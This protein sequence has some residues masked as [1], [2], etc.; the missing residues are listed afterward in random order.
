MFQ[1]NS[2]TAAPRPRL[3]D[4]ALTVEDMLQLWTKERDSFAYKSWKL[5]KSVT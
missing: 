4:V 2:I 3:L 1:S 5:R